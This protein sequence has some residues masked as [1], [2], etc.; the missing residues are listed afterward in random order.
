MTLCL[1]NIKGYKTYTAT[2]TEHSFTRSEW[3]SGETVLLTDIRK[4]DGRNKKYK[5]VAG[6]MWVG[7]RQG[8][9]E[10]DAKYGY[11]SPT[12]DMAVGDA[13]D[14]DRIRFDAKVG[15]YRKG[16]RCEEK[17]YKFTDI[18]NVCLIDED[19]NEID[20]LGDLV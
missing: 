13:E 14:G 10:I 4:L 7:E 8:S 16:R 6:H 12:G 9:I 20:E 17:D 3:L 15:V 1:A 2:V 5:P 18:R 11:P 19:G